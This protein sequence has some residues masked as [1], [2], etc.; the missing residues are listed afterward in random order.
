MEESKVEGV[1]K[2]YA[3]ILDMQ[4]LTAMHQEDI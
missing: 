3:F 4:K 1:T 2:M